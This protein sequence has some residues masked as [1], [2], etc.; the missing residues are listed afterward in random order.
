MSDFFS[1][2]EFSDLLKEM[3]PSGPCLALFRRVLLLSLNGVTHD[4]SYKVSLFLLRTCFYLS[5]FELF[6]LIFSVKEHSWLNWCN[7]WP[8]ALWKISEFF[9]VESYLRGISRAHFK[10]KFG[11]VSSHLCVTV[12]FTSHA[13][14]SDKMASFA[15]PKFTAFIY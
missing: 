2:Q 15:V 4:P 9:V 1:L 14:P 5:H 7:T 8:P 12:W 10:S 6:T 3:D 11:S 13:N